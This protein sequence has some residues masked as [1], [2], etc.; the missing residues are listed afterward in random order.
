[1]ESATKKGFQQVVVRV[2]DHKTNI[3]T[4]GGMVVVVILTL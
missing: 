4:G 3:G 2:T 1:M